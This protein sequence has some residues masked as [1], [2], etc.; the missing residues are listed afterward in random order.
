MST[1]RTGKEQDA[2]PTEESAAFVEFDTKRMIGQIMLNSI[3]VHW[4]DHK[5]IMYFNHP[6]DIT[7]YS[8]RAVLSAQPIRPQTSDIALQAITSPLLVIVGQN[9]ELFKADKFTGFISA[10]SQGKTIIIDAETHNGIL[11]SEPAFSAV[12]D[13]YTDMLQMTQ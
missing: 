1:Q 6:T 2:T 11:T 12:H 10:N 13:W 4:L 7:A 9:D 8:Y 5:P 3:G